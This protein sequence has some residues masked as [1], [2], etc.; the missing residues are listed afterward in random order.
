MDHRTS[1]KPAQQSPRRKRADAGAGLVESAKAREGARAEPRHSSLTIRLTAEERAAIDAAA[2][3]R[4]WA[5]STFTRWA[6]LWAA[7]KRRPDNVRRK[8]AVDVEAV[9]RLVGETGRLRRAIGE[10]T[11]EARAGHV[12]AP[13]MHAMI[14]QMTALRDEVTVLRQAVVGQERDS[15]RSGTPADPDTPAGAAT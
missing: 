3:S 7:D 5:P 13:A 2:A 1:I 6:V 15:A 14:D 9:A 8:P 4:F 12:D 11:D 10:L